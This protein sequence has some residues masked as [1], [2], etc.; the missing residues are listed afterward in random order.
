MKDG[1]EVRDVIF[2]GLRKISLKELVESSGLS[3]KGEDLKL[4]SFMDSTDVKLILFNK[5]KETKQVSIYNVSRVDVPD[6]VVWSWNEVLEVK[7][8]EEKVFEYPIP[9]PRIPSFDYRDYTGPLRYAIMMTISDPTQNETISC[10]VKYYDLPA[11]VDVDKVEQ[12]DF[13]IH[14]ALKELKR[15]T[16]LHDILIDGD[17]KDGLKSIKAKLFNFGQE[18]QYIGI[19]TRVEKEGMGV[20]DTVLL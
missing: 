11:I 9:M 20:S 16:I 13:D 1:L 14:K 3:L 15:T 5:S 17:A 6:G 4:E 2:G 10:R 19:D 12:S 8:D 7:P 18:T